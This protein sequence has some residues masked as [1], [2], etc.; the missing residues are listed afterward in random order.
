[1]KMRIAIIAACAGALALSVSTGAFAKEVKKPIGPRKSPQV[2]NYYVD[3]H[4]DKLSLSNKRNP[5]GRDGK[6]TKG[7]TLPSNGFNADFDGDQR[8]QK[9]KPLAKTR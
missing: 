7:S 9:G 1:M 2:I 8:T 4:S 6:T 3:G 5:S